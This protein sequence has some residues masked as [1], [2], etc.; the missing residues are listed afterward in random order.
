M[1]FC[2]AY[3]NYILATAFKGN[4]VGFEALDAIRRGELEHKNS[5]QYYVSFCAVVK[6]IEMKKTLIIWNQGLYGIL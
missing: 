6:L 3:S 1:I 5:W 2:V 4:K